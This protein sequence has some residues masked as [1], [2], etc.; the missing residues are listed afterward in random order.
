MNKKHSVVVVP[1]LGD[2]ISRLKWAT[3]HWHKQGLEPIVHSVGWRNFETEFKPKLERLDSLIDQL[4]DKGDM[5]SLVGTSAGGSAVINAF[6]ERR[7]VIHKVIN[8]CGRLRKGTQTGFRSFEARSASS[9]AFAQ[10]V[11]LCETNLESLTDIDKQ[12]IMTVRAMFG[13]ELVPP[14]TTIVKGALNIQ[15]PTPEHVLSIGAALTVFSKP[16]I[17]FLAGNEET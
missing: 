3:D 12:K 7:D 16:L 4:V 17:I 2:D 14:D 6:F 13:D 5:V 9:P 10:S 11:Q 1:G 8:V 15:V